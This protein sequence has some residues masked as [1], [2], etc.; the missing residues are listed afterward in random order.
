MKNYYEILQISRTATNDVIR[1]AYKALSV[2]YHPDNNKGF[3]EE[4]EIKFKEVQEAY[5]TLSDPEKRIQYDRILDEKNKPII[6]D[7]SREEIDKSSHPKKQGQNKSISYPI[8]MGIGLLLF[9]VWN[10]RQIF[11][12]SESAATN[13][14]KE[15][16]TVEETRESTT[17]KSSGSF[18]DYVHERRAQESAENVKETSTFKTVSMPENGRVYRNG[19]MGKDTTSLELEAGDGNYF[20]KVVDDAGYTVYMVFV[21]SNH[22]V[23]IMLNEG[24][25]TLKA[26]TGA[27]WYGMGKYFGEEGYYSETEPFDIDLDHTYNLTLYMI[28]GGN[29][30]SQTIDLSDF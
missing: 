17:S 11:D 27:N 23:T 3:P 9:L 25:Y 20:V 21:R 19:V 15:T 22:S 16:T 1:A 12:G 13:I 7:K 24:T 14:P 4:A 28:E 2:K 26:G 8:L 5:E 29:T 10:G 30:D 18:S 6:N